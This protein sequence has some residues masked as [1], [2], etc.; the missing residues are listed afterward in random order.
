MIYEVNYGIHK[1][2]FDE[3]EAKD[4]VEAKEKAQELVEDWLKNLGSFSRTPS[5]R[6]SDKNFIYTVG[7]IY[8]LKYYTKQ[9]PAICK[10]SKRYY[11]GK[12][13]HSFRY[14]SPPNRK[15]SSYHWDG[16]SG[17][18][19][20]LEGQNPPRVLKK[21][22]DDGIINK[23]ECSTCVSKFHCYTRKGAI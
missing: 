11:G 1:S 3:I 14:L 16:Y 10:D 18:W 4:E 15:N 22:C 20:N 6:V 12:Y 2:L 17:P 21:L 13:Y 8:L 9:L 7:G 19:I 23:P 5:V